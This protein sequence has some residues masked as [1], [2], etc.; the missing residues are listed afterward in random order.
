MERGTTGWLVFFQISDSSFELC[1]QIEQKHGVRPRH[2]MAEESDKTTETKCKSF[3]LFGN[4]CSFSI[5]NQ[6]LSRTC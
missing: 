3:S 5:L 4:V 2:G 1:S 6:L